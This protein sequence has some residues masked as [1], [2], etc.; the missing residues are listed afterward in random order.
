MTH[1]VYGL[2]EYLK[3]YRRT[4]APNARRLHLLYAGKEDLLLRHGRFFTPQ[5]RPGRYRQRRAK[6]CFYNAFMLAQKTGLRYVEGVAIGNIRLNYPV[7]HAWCVDDDDCVVDA[8][9]ANPG[10]AYFG[11]EFAIQRVAREP[12]DKSTFG[13]LLDNWAQDYPV[14]REPYTH[15]EHAR[16]QRK[17]K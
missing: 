10:L 11:V 5:P 6:A 12:R 8:T 2:R 15:P 4:I 3:R 7:H 16:L 17:G 13:S 9:W 1:D 14:L